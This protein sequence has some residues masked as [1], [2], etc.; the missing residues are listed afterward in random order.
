MTRTSWW[1]QCWA[2]CCIRCRPGI[3]VTRVRMP[4]RGSALP[5]V[6][7]V[8]WR[9]LRWLCVGG[10]GIRGVCR[11]VWLAR[12]WWLGRLLEARRSWCFAMS[13]L[14]LTVKENLL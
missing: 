8:P 3:G 14:T 1:I 9:C 10:A 5:V 12:L 13:V 6:G 7:V 4:A 2:G 11:V